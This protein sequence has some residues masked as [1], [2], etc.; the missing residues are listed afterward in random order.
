MQDLRFGGRI[1]F[2]VLERTQSADA[3][4][5]CLVVQPLVE[6]AVNHGV[7]TYI[8]DGLIRISVEDE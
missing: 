4:L 6:N 5:P 2:E 3:M 7:K 1:R 8:R